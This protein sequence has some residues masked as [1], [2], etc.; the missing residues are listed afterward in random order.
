M[1]LSIAVPWY[2]SKDSVPVL[3]ERCLAA[4]DRMPEFSAIEFVFVEDCGRDG[5]WEALALL[6]AKDPRVKVARFTRNFGQHHTITACLDLCQG[7]WVVVMDCDLQDRPEEIPRLWAKAREEELDMVCARRGRRKD[8]LW[9][10]SSSIIFASV[11][12]WLTGMKTDSQVGNFRIMK[13]SVVEALQ[14]MRESTRCLGAQLNWLG[15][16]G[17]F[18]DV[19][20]ASRFSGESSYT[21][22]KLFRLAADEIIS[23][24]DKP[25]RISIAVGAALSCV[26]L[27]FAAAI[28]C[29]KLFMGVEISGW[30]SIMVSIWFLGGLLIGNLGIIGLYLGKIYTEVKRRPIY[31]IA[32]QINCLGSSQS[33]KCASNAAL[34][35]SSFKSTAS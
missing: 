14:L 32:E 6:A 5:T 18:V 16:T 23:Y 11:F 34:Y 28:V 21:L 22:T 2:K 30:A 25:L 13:K 19:E 35:N 1:L 15:F 10:R 17:G 27:L 4:F 8:S 9:K 3:Y 20:H 33:E 31:V 7:D 29:K 24:S 26:S 12:N